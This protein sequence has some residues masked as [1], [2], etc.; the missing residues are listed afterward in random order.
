[1][2][3]KLLQ[4]KKYRYVHI[5]ADTANKLLVSG[6]AAKRSGTERIILH[7]HSSGIDGGHRIIKRVFHILC[8]RLLKWIGTDFVSCSDLAAKWMFPNIPPQQIAIINNGI[9][10]EQFRFCSETRQLVRTTLGL[11]DEL[12]IGHVG[13]FNYQK[14]H[15]FLIR[16]MKEISERDASVKLL[17]IGKGDLEDD[18][19]QQVRKYGLDGCVIFYGITD[20]VHKLMQ[21]MD[22]FALPSHFEGLPIVGVEAQAAGLPAVFAQPV[23]SEAGVLENS[24]FLPITENAVSTW[25]DTIMRLSKSA[26]DRS[27]A[28][29]VLKSKG[30]DISSTVNSFLHLYKS[31]QDTQENKLLTQKENRSQ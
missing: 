22:V 24:V 11:T 13:R 1:M 31:E 26:T 21:A 29:S 10:L 15:S 14:N 8:R 6:I 4:K 12:L 23:T 28:Y 2:L 30:F 18:I 9:R 20:Q 27:A 17:L 25:A 16:V 19:R 5:H 3:K 7:S